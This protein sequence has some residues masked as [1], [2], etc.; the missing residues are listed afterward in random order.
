MFVD[1]PEM[2]EALR[3][4]TEA[5]KSAEGFFMRWV[6]LWGWIPEV[7]EL[8]RQARMKLD[9]TTTLSPRERAVIVCAT[10]SG[11]G[12]SYCSLAWGRRLAK[13]SEP[14]I[15]AELIK[16]GDANAL[17]PRERALAAW[18][19]RVV[20]N[21]SGTTRDEVDA[22]RAAGLSQREIVEATTLV[23]FRVAFAM[24]NSA[25][26][27][28][29]DGPLGELAPVEVRDAVTFGRPIGD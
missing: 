16:T 26:G 10:V 13:L 7:E 17:S 25:L 2:T 6:R 4:R 27:A 1:E 19:R 18:S 8:F 3:A 12:D 14:T 5:V 20:A 29:P 24:V 15:P 11:V 21:P 23:A 22:L 28:Q 9:A